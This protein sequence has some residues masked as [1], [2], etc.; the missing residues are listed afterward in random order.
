MNASKNVMVM[1]SIEN[2]WYNRAQMCL[3]YDACTLKD[4]MHSTIETSCLTEGLLLLPFTHIETTA[5]E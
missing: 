4:T 1:G 3:K 5:G 2:V